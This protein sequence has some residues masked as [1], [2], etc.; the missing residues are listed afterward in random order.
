MRFVSSLAVLFNFMVCASIPHCR[1]L[2]LLQA[3]VIARHTTDY[4]A[5]CIRF[6]PFET[7]RLVTCGRSS[8]RIYRLKAS[9]LM[10]LRRRAVISRAS[11]I[12]R[13]SGC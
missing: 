1:L 2:M 6:C 7:G 10:L 8:I 3:C 12:D 11:S 13:A 5:S 4:H 9:A